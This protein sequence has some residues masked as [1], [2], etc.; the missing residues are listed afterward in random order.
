MLDWLIQQAPVIVVMGVVI[1]WLQRELRE[2]RDD[3]KEANLRNHETN[4]QV[5]KLTTLWEATAENIGKARKQKADAIHN[6]VLEVI[7]EIR[8]LKKILLK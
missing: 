5:I 8:S 1:W 7:G 4:E 3:L 2:T 6:S